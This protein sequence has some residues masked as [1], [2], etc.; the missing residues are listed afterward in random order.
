MNRKQRRAE[1]KQTGKLPPSAP[2]SVHAGFTAALQHHQSGRLDEAERH[3]RQVLAIDCRHADSLHLLGVLAHQTG[4]HDAAIDLIRRAIAIDAGTAAYHSNLASVLQ[5]QGRLD[6]AVACCRRALEL[7]PD[8]PAAHKNLASAL[9]EQGRPDEAAAS[10]RRA[11]TLA[12]DDAETQCRLGDALRQQQQLDE[13]VACYRRALVLRPGYWEALINL[14]NALA[15]QGRLDEAVSCCRLAAG[16]SPGVAEAH[17]N[18]GNLLQRQDRLDEAAASYRRALELRPGYTEAHNN[19]ANALKEQGRLDEAAASCRRALRLSPDYAEAHYN[20]GNVLMEQERLDEAAACFRRA[21]ALRPDDPATHN[22]LGRVLKRQG[23][24]DE[25]L[26]CWRAALALQPDFP[27]AHTNLAMALLA[28]GELAEGWREYEWR[29]HSPL[30]RKTRRN[31]DR[32]Q[33]RGEAA[34]GRTLL[35]HAEQGFGDT[36]QFCR[37]APLAAASGL[38]VILEAPKP[39]VRLLRRLDGVD[40]VVE[41]GAPLPEFDLHCPIL[42]L[43]LAQGTTLASIP[44]TTYLRADPQQE[45]GWRTRLAAIAGP[46]RRIGLAWAGNPAL[47]ADARRSLPPALLAPLF[48]VP[49]LHFV[50]LQKGGAAAPA[51]FPLTDLMD[52]MAD[53]AGTASLI[54]GLDLVIAADTAVAHLAAGLGRPVWLLDRFDPC[55]RWLAGRRDSPWYPTLRLYRQPAPGDWESVI[56]EVVRDLGRD[57][58]ES[59]RQPIG[60]PPES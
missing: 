18:L 60:P 29:W 51:D 12:P 20:L 40:L 49:G 38:R 48:A 56:A 24:P 36:L 21:L 22:N 15:A 55:W 59:P 41:A 9:K 37:Y 8:Y 7:R 34:T 13:A 26:A 1:A 14:A 45:A 19:L 10:Y 57:A 50:S 11:L 35:I 47:P 30:M 3:Y 58:G 16:S 46:G 43:P 6:E 54:A 27:D 5:R 44:A 4:R 31:F 53:F 52:E 39:L 2:P 25:A 32:P 42:S 28:R 23:R 33:W 17:Y